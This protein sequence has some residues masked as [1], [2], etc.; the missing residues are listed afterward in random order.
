[1][2]LLNDAEHWY[3]HAIA[4]NP[5]H[6]LSY[7][8]LGVLYMNIGRQSLALHY[9][10][11]GLAV[12]PHSELIQSNIPSVRKARVL[13][14][15]E[16]ER[17]YDEPSAC[18]IAPICL[19]AQRASTWGKPLTPP[20]ARSPKTAQHPHPLVS[21]GTGPVN[22]ASSFSDNVRLISTPDESDIPEHATPVQLRPEDYIQLLERALKEQPNNIQFRKLAVETCDSMGRVECGQRHRRLLNAMHPPNPSAGKGEGNSKGKRGQ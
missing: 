13:V 7:N 1:M 6:V 19:S 18:T 14:L 16:I 10:K 20:P 22:Y 12:D 21:A 4:H 17:V 11:Q 8:N 3:L 5:H 2:N 15:S 9:F